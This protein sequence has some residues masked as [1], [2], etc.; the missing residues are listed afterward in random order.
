LAE[1]N[2]MKRASATIFAACLAPA[3]GMLAAAAERTGEPRQP[4][5]EVAAATADAEAN[6]VAEARLRSQLLHE[7]IH[8]ALQVMH[9]DLFRDGD[10][11]LPI[12]SQSLEDVFAELERTWQVRVKWLA[13]NA[14]VMNA[15]N[16]PKTEFDKLAAAAIAG[17]SEM[18]EASADGVYQY[19]GKI[20]LG[21]QC[22]KCHVPQRT[23][24]EDR[25]AAVVISMPL[26]VKDVSAK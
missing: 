13:V 20:T 2:A 24:L 3:L 14:K 4:A 10:G 16:R 11:R 21:N 18:F 8:G 12:P 19:A 22:L 25:M 15:K 9:R 5:R 23:S 7:T 26:K 6:Q 1:R 17:G